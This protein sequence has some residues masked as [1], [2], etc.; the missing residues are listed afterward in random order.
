MS[1]YVRE[2]KNYHTFETHNYLRA[3]KT[4][5]LVPCPKKNCRKENKKKTEAIPRI[6]MDSEKKNLS[7][8]CPSRTEANTILVK[9]RTHKSPRKNIKKKKKK[10]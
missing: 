9:C 1:P 3:R 5:L 6:L 8:Y 7:L 10:Q 4:L 2:R